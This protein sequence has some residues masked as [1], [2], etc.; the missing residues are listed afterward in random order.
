MDI[1]L[2]TLLDY[3]CLCLCSC[4]LAVTDRFTI[5]SLQRRQS[6]I[7][8]YQIYKVEHLRISG[9]SFDVEEQLI[10]LSI[11]DVDISV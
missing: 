9:Y 7:F 6:K 4:L 5:R 3:I 8:T 11:R 10:R 2:V 1:M